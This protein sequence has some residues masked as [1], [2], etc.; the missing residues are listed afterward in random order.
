MKLFS[1]CMFFLS[2][3]FTS[4]TNEE[5]ISSKQNN[6]VGSDYFTAVVLGEDFDCKGF[7]DIQIL[8]S[9]IIEKNPSPIKGVFVALGLPQSLEITGINIKIKFRE[10]NDEDK[11]PVCTRMGQTFAAIIILSAKKIE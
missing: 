8:D 3:V 6:E 7:Y 1:Y 2:I 10:V 11:L 4:C 5:S 9:T